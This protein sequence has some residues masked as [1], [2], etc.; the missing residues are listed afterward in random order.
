MLQG[1]AA[2]T[3]FQG[4]GAAGDFNNITYMGYPVFVC[5]GMFNK[6]IVATYKSNMVFGT[7]LA[8]DWTEAKIIPTYQYDGSDN[9]RVTMNFALGV[10][11][12]VA[13]DGVVGYDLV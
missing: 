2:N 8:T 5:P 6:T 3:T 4:L 9:V 1:L 7:N 13:G 10:Q 12:A 11:T